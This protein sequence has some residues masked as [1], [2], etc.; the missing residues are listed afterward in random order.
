MAIMVYYSICLLQHVI[1]Y[2][3]WRHKALAQLLEEYRPDEVH[4]G[5]ED[6]AYTREFYSILQY[7]RLEFIGNTVR[8]T[9]IHYDIL[10]Y[11]IIYCNILLWNAE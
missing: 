9:M 2:Y 7:T 11:I 10:Q 8:Y 3:S 5:E 1:S 4:E 6:T